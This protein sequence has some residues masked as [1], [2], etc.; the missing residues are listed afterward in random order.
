MMIAVNSFKTE[1][2][3]YANGPFALPQTL[4]LDIITSTWQRTEYIYNSLKKLHVN[5]LI[6][7]KRQ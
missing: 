6:M 4:N 3:Y 2:E 7:S 5:Q 1:T